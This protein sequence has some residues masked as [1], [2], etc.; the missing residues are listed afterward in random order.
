PPCL[1]V[2]GA[3][4]NS[5][6]VVGSWCRKRVAGGAH[7]QLGTHACLLSWS[8]PSIALQTQRCLI[9]VHS[10]QRRTKI[11]AYILRGTVCHP[12]PPKSVRSQRCRSPASTRVRYIR[13][14]SARAT[15][16]VRTA[17]NTTNA[18][19][20]RRSQPGS[21][22]PSPE[23]AFQSH[24]VRV[25]R[26]R[27]IL[28]AQDRRSAFEM[29]LGATHES[30]IVSLVNFCV[31]RNRHRTCRAR[32]GYW[33]ASLPNSMSA[34]MTS[35]QSLIAES[36]SQSRNA[37]FI[38][39][40]EE[41]RAIA[42]YSDRIDRQTVVRNPVVVFDGGAIVD[43]DV[44]ETIF[45]H[46][47]HSSRKVG[48]DATPSLHAPSMLQVTMVAGSQS[49]SRHGIAK[50]QNAVRGRST[51]RPPDGEIYEVPERGLGRAYTDAYISTILQA[52]SSSIPPRLAVS[53]RHPGIRPRSPSAFCF[54]D[55]DCVRSS[56]RSTR[57]AE[58]GKSKARASDTSV[59][60][61]LD[62]RAC[63]T[64]NKS[65]S[66]E[67]MARRRACGAG[68]PSV[69]RAVRTA[70]RV[71]ACAEEAG[72]KRRVVDTE[73]QPPYACMWPLKDA[74]DSAGRTGFPGPAGSMRFPTSSSSSTAMR[75][76]KVTS[77]DAY[78]TLC[79]IMFACGVKLRNSAVMSPS[80]V[81]VHP[82]DF[83][84]SLDVIST[85]FMLV[86]H[87]QAFRVGTSSCVQ[88]LPDG[89]PES[90]FALDRCT[91]DS[92]GTDQ[93][94]VFR[95]S[96]TVTSEDAVAACKMPLLGSNASRSHE[97]HRVVV[98][99][100]CGYGQSNCM[101]IAYANLALGRSP[102]SSIPADRTAN[103]YQAGEKFE[104]KKK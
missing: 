35:N 51:D 13:A 34:Q 74:D 59:V 1:Y 30:P 40:C 96:I 18:G 33:N 98:K 81:S 80:T 7:G 87:L 5:E 68:R 57:S 92:E 95:T 88:P 16:C 61:V 100:G 58:V 101:S 53:T 79:S 50:P 19:S 67:R 36:L 82:P 60:T 28:A 38:L 69:F 85:L 44:L 42:T 32:L 48:S 75:D 39:I 31:S 64:M 102:A 63:Y 43:D 14:G 46:T 22:V 8:H 17:T 21:S 71:R 20:C 37:Y 27:P 84:P 3:S 52:S 45:D 89:S 66:G 97:D 49:P 29:T 77:L 94:P 93:T 9:I 62:E 90:C 78:G 83:I 86:S 76:G 103:A 104:L 4:C 99:N 6:A 2:F 23:G 70:W 55:V 54:D 72:D 12:S 56:R 10:R 47:D 15:G 26:S 65:K 91:M 11:C 41:A 25:L 24:I 73:S